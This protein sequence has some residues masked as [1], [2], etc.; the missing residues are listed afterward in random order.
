[1]CAL[2]PWYGTVVEEAARTII[3][4]SDLGGVPLRDVLVE[5]LGV[6]EHCGKRNESTENIS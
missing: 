1:M 3:H 6:T 4:E 5:A 2:Q